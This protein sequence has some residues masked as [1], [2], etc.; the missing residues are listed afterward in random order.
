M[1][2]EGCLLENKPHSIVMIHVYSV[3]CISGINDFVN[4]DEE[5][6]CLFFLA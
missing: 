6:S 5:I 4:H 3:L 1:M 2:V